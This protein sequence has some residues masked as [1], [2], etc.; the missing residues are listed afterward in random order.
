MSLDKIAIVSDPGEWC[1]ALASVAEK[2]SDGVDVFAGFSEIQ[3]KMTLPGYRGIVVDLDME[4]GSAM[5]IVR[6]LT[7]DAKET[8]FVLIGHAPTH[9]QVDECVSLG[10]GGVVR[11]PENT[12]NLRDAM[13]QVSDGT[14]ALVGSTEMRKLEFTVNGQDESLDK[15]IQVLSRLLRDGGLKSSLEFNRMITAAYEAL[16]N[17]VEHGNEGKKELDIHVHYHWCRGQLKVIIKDNGEGFDPKLVPNP[18]QPQNLLKES[19][20]GLLIIRK[21]ADKLW[22]EEGGTRIIFEKNLSSLID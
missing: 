3:E 14:L 22:F 6:T 15:A 12:E 16:A 7:R 17:A 11:K 19:G 10:V 5:E 21:Y 18:L 2:V 1:D 20:R 4:S 13:L 9:D 8:R